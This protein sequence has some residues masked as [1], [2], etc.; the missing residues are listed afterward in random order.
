LWGVP[1][2]YTIVGIAQC[3]EPGLLAPALP[4]KE[5]LIVKRI[6][7]VVILALVM[8]ATMAVMVVPA[9]A[10]PAVPPDQR[11]VICPRYICNA[12]DPTECA[13]E[14]TFPHADLP[15]QPIENACPPPPVTNPA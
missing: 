9:F 1:T 15:A 3:R 5:W 7:M 14:S 10:D 12:L 4:R 8:A 13:L 6:L 2:P 11:P